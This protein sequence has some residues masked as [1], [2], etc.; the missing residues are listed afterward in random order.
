DER[1]FVHG[2]RLRIVH[3]PP[4]LGSLRLLRITNFCH[5][6][7]ISRDRAMSPPATQKSAAKHG[8]TEYPAIRPQA[9]QAENVLAGLMLVT[10]PDQYAP[11]TT[12]IDASLELHLVGDRFHAAD[13]TSDRDCAVDVVARAHET[14]Q[15]NDALEGV[16]PDLG[17]LQVWR[18]ED[19]GPDFGRDDAVIDILASRLVRA[20]GRATQ[21]CHQQHR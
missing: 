12:V 3:M 13:R 7:A 17:G 2:V 6:L 1:R 11:I 15:L 18:V 10:C 9:T 8:S 21:D 19:R 14:S 20:R 16:D 4:A 5:A